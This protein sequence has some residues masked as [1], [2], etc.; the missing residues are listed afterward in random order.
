MQ[1]EDIEFAPDT[2]WLI[3]TLSPFM[4]SLEGA[5]IYDLDARPARIRE[6]YEL[7]NMKTYYQLFQ[8]HKDRFEW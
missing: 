4:L 6:W 1:L 8:K 2:K 3:A 5:R 7:E